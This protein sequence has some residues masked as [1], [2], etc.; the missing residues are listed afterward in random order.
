MLD[1]TRPRLVAFRERVAVAVP[2]V[3]EDEGDG[4]CPKAWCSFWGATAVTGLG[5]DYQA[6]MVGRLTV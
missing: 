2:C 6:T 1:F 4:S 3:P 5:R